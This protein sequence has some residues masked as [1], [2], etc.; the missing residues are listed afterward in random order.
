MR[1][2]ARVLE[3]DWADEHEIEPERIEASLRRGQLWG[4]TTY[5][6]LFGEK[7][8]HRGRF[9]EA[10]RCI[11]Q[12]D[13]IRDLFRFDLAKTNYYYLNTL[14]PLER[15]DLARAIEA[16]DAYYDHNPEDLL[17]ILALSAKAKAQVLLGDLASA[18]ISLALAG[19]L[20]ASSAPV[21]PFHASA[22]H[23]SQ[24]LFDVVALER[25]QE[26]EPGQRR[27]WR[28]RARR[29]V[30]AALRSAGHVAWR[31]TEV[32]R[33]AGRLRWLG[34]DER[35][36]MSL[37]QRSLD[38]GHALGAQPEIARSYEELGRLLLHGGGSAGSVPENLDARR[39]FELARTTYQSL[40]LTGDL[41]R[42]ESLK[43]PV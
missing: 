9:D 19:D 31:R 4:P 22:Y 38:A 27:H 30:R 36:A 25:A 10:Q 14:L 17:H 15:G 24:L 16:A 7:Q 33:L 37:M 8:I 39:C 41:A 26:S 28:S 12:I 35:A 42:L 18:E 21:P 3:G 1:F 32:L 11:E 23:R 34:G 43:N 5:L 29:S 13:E 2:A 40:A 20:M 6:G